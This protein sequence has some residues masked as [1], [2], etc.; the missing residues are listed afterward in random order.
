MT[1]KINFDKLEDKLKKIGG[2]YNEIASK[3]IDRAA[4]T[5]VKTIVQRTSQKS[6][7]KDGRSFKA[8]SDSYA[9]HKKKAGAPKRVI[10]SNAQ[11]KQAQPPQPK[12]FS[13]QD[14]FANNPQLCAPG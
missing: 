13:S 9:K 12:P 14:S 7:D 1:L 11:R 5:A 4:Q 8:Y 6:K 10:R 3:A 2:E